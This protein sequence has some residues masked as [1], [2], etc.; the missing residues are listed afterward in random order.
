MKG[1]YPT[2]S[3]PNF[4]KRI[5]NKQEFAENKLKL[6]R[7]PQEELC[8]KTDVQLF[9]HQ[10]LVRNFMSP[11][12]PYQNLL[13]IHAPGLGKTISAI[14]VAESHVSDGI[15]IHVLLEDSV[16]QNFISEYQKY[17]GD[18][19]DKNIYKIHT[20]GKFTN[21]IQDLLKTTAGINEIKK[22]YSN[23]VIIVDEVHNIRESTDEDPSNLKRYAALRS[24]VTLANNSK[25]LLMSAT[26]MYDSPHEIVSLANLF[27][28]NGTNDLTLSDIPRLSIN[29]NDI[30]NGNNLT[31]LG[32]KILQQELKGTISFLKEDSRTYPSSGFPSSA[33]NYKSL[34]LSIIDC[35]MSKDHLEFYKKNLSETNVNNIRQNSNIID[36]VIRSSDLTENALGNETTSV[37]SKFYKLLNNINN[38]SGS[39]FVYSEFIGTSLERI[40]MMLEQNGYHQYSPNKS[41]KS[42][43]FLEGSQALDK[44][45][46]LIEIFNSDDNKN[47]DIIK[48]VLGSRVLKEGITLKNVQSVHIIEPWHNMSRLLQIWG[49]A[50]RTCSHVAL[51]PNKR[52]VDIYLYASTFGTS[53]T[54]DDL[55]KPFSEGIV[56][57]DIYAYYRSQIK[58]VAI[59]NVIR[60]LRSIAIDCVIQKNYNKNSIDGIVCADTKELKTIDKSTYK[61]NEYYFKKPEVQQR[62]REL[63]N[64]I[65]TKYI[66]IF[67]GRISTVDAYAIEFIVPNN[68]TNIKS[69]EHLITDKKGN[70]G[71]II[72]RGKYLLFQPLNKNANI[73]LFERIHTKLE[74]AKNTPLSSRYIPK[75][76][77]VEQPEVNTIRPSVSPRQQRRQSETIP[78]MD[79][80]VHGNYRGIIRNGEFLLQ[81]IENAGKNATG[82]VCANYNGRDFK[83]IINNIRIPADKVSEFYTEV[84]GVPRIKNKQK[85]CS[86]LMTYFYPSIQVEEQERERDIGVQRKLIGIYE[87]R[88]DNGMFKIMNTEIVGRGGNNCNTMKVDTLREI[89][90]ILEIQT[91]SRDR[92]TL[93]ELIK[94]KVFG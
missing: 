3:D 64:D 4:N 80:A 89:S 45:S 26:P 84:N 78:D 42:F 90:S 44:R 74:K 9:E 24:V 71:Y 23:S 40:K 69:F 11:Y 63:K 77:E 61:L 16:R 88:M 65:A 27:I 87:F 59:K 20:L 25:L 86:T 22:T 67:N 81:Q 58:E 14:S 2:I 79:N 35:P 60:L 43:I 32:E 57:Y 7:T 34:G 1:Y 21:K 30:F 92:K 31:S 37:S 48:I 8:I 33:K 38:A 66:K 13:L 82:R 49:R 10:R 55:E 6:T 39:L 53:I 85:L 12:T 18:K 50:I 91:N 29:L 17:T 76:R 5:T 51:P 36:T 75:G 54:T 68:R 93:C 56:P 62:I 47:G 46:K 70:E 19:L 15:T 52:H 41:G 28:L 94:N 83:K 72:K 73:S